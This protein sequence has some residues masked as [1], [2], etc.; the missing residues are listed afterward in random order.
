MIAKFL[1][2]IAIMSSAPTAAKVAKIVHH[3]EVDGQKFKV[4]QQGSVAKVR[5]VGLVLVAPTVNLMVRQRKAAE[6]AT[7]CKVSHTYMMY[8]TILVA[9]LNCLTMPPSAP[10]K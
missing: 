6:I 5:R 3:V 4:S 10:I 2:L 1:V 7:G 8:E 9:E